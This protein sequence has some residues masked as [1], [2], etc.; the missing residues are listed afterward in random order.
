MEIKILNYSSVICQIFHTPGNTSEA[1]YSVEQEKFLSA[2]VQL[3]PLSALRDGSSWRLTDSSLSINS[4]VLAAGGGGGAG[5]MVGNMSATTL[6]LPPPYHH[7][8]HHQS[9]SYPTLT[10]EIGRK[11]N[12]LSK[13][14]N[15]LR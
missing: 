14:M 7:Y 11:T 13:A 3:T 2:V 15:T 8:H 5:G 6:E 4:L 10:P 12:P 1:S 9:S